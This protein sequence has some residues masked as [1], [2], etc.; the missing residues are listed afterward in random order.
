MLTLIIPFWKLRR[1]RASSGVV[2]VGVG[3]VLK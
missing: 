3:E 1:P 2:S